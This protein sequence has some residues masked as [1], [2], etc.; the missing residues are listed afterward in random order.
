[1]FPRRA[2]VGL[3]VAGAAH[4]DLLETWNDAARGRALPVRLRWPG[5]PW[6]V[7]AVVFS[8]G[9]GGTRDAMGYLGQALRDAG[10]ACVHL[11]HPGSDATLM[12]DRPDRRRALLGGFNTRTARDRLLDVG[13]ALDRLMH[14]PRI[15]PSRLA[16]A[17]HS[18][19]ARTTLTMLGMASPDAAGLGLPD[20]RL[21][22]GVALSPNADADATEATFAAIRAPVLH[23][24]GTRDGDDLRLRAPVR[25]LLPARLTRHAHA[26]LHVLEGANHFDFG[27]EGLRGS[28]AIQQVTA[29]LA[30]DFLGRV[31]R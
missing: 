6:R 20:R 26:A 4:A 27:N 19:G 15:D 28:A 2:L 18:F 22:A 24:T 13:F 8:H 17:G 11:Q 31:L 1:M 5:T 12:A 10:F 14:D 21:R 23:I 3:L 25:R 7:P 29:R 9:L 16:I 30:V